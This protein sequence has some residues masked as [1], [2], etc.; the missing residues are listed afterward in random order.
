[1]CRRCCRKTLFDEPSIVWK[2]GRTARREGVTFGVTLVGPHQKGADINNLEGDCGSHSLPPTLIRCLP[3][4]PDNIRSIGLFLVCSVPPCPRAASR[5]Y[6]QTG[7]GVAVTHAR[8][9]SPRR[10]PTGLRGGRA[11]VLCL[12]S[13]RSTLAQVG[14]QRC[15]T[16]EEFKAWSQNLG[17]SGASRPSRATV[18]LRRRG[19]PRSFGRWVGQRQA[20]PTQRTASQSLRTLFAAAS[21]ADEEGHCR[22]IRNGG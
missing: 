1:M 6:P 19:R 14:E 3:E 18:A 22:L 12:H 5:S 21:E 20:G 9:L 8:K 11:A 17:H 10:I 16:P 2:A 4:R 13:L 15:Q 7:V